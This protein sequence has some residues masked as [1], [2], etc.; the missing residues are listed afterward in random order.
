MILLITSLYVLINKQ[1]EDKENNNLVEQLIEDVI[2]EKEVENENTHEDTLSIDWN[3][4]KEINE[5]IIAWIKIEGTNINYPILKDKD[6]YYLKHSYNKQWNSNG[7]IFVMNNKPFEENKTVVYGHNMRNGIM[8]SELGKYLDE[9]FFYAHRNFE[10]YT[11]GKN[12][13][14]TVLSCYSIGVNAEENNIKD[15]DFDE[16]IQ[17]YKN[18]SK[19]EVNNIENVKKIVKLSTCSYLNNR[20]IPTDQRYFVIAKIEEI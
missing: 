15:L 6:L 12:Y 9:D 16:E 2:V 3:K 10:I 4:L 13:K 11:Q 18:K 14:A 19:Y 20:R 1:I 5:D 17:Y 8:F 7:S